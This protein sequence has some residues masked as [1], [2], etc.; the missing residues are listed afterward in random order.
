MA[1]SR[2]CCPVTIAATP[3]G[4]HFSFKDTAQHAFRFRKVVD[5]VALSAAPLTIRQQ[6]PVR[7]VGITIEGTITVALVRLLRVHEYDTG[8]YANRHGI[9]KSGREGRK[10]GGTATI[11]A[12]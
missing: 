12:Q 6:R 1:L 4:A 5:S 9:L 8:V 11:S 7:D 2:A 10:L 3:N